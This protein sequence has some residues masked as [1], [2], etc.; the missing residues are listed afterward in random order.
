M[1]YL[2][3][4]GDRLQG[5]LC[6]TKLQSRRRERT[7]FIEQLEMRLALS[8]LIAYEDHFQ[9]RENV[10]STVDAPGV[11]ANDDSNNCW[12]PYTWSCMSATGHTPVR[13]TER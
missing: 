7:L 8:R 12:V 5:I 11:L 6:R 13:L 1:P 9:V 4:L 3:T 10:T 2:K